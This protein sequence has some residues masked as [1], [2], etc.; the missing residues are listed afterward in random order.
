MALVKEEYEV[1]P[2]P[3]ISGSIV[4]SLS[5]NLAMTV[6]ELALKNYCKVY[7]KQ[8]QKQKGPVG[9][10]GDAVKQ[11]VDLVLTDPPYSIGR[12]AA[13]LGAKHDLCTVNDMH[14]L[15][16]VSAEV[17][18]MLGNGH[19]FCSEAQFSQCKEVPN[20]AEESVTTED[21]NGEV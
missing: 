9:L 2:A 19:I 13:R 21:S 16:D 10:D 7:D 14:A 12:E 18:K 15:I 11:T 20:G 8:L 4:D 17:I 6:L 1:F 5:R 3:S